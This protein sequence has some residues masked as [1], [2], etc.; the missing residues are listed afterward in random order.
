M[1]HNITCPNCSKERSVSNQQ[2]QQRKSDLCHACNLALFPRTEKMHRAKQIKADFKIINCGFCGKD[3]KR[4]AKQRATYDNQYCDIK[5][6]QAAMRTGRFRACRSC[7]K[8]RFQRPC[9]ATA[10]KTHLCY[11]CEKKKIHELAQWKPQDC[12]YCGQPIKRPY[13]R[14]EGLTKRLRKKNV[15]HFCGAPCKIAMFRDL[16]KS[17]VFVFGERIDRSGT[18]GKP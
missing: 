6:R 8:L 18:E 16:Y 17:G 14:A 9:E 10:A 3:I 5:C 15:Y 1:R 2:F 13:W 4:S 11:E 12:D 7:G